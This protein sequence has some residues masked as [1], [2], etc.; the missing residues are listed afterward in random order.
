MARN[1]LHHRHVR[2]NYRV[3][4]VLVLVAVPLLAI[5][6]LVILGIGQAQSRDTYGAHLEQIAERTAAAVDTFVLRRVIDVSLLARVP[7]VREAA[8]A[9]GRIPFDAGAVREIDQ[10]WQRQQAPPPAAGNVLSNAASRFFRDVAQNDPIYS[11]LLLTDAQ[12]RLVAASEVTS[13]YFQADEEWWR[14]AFSR[15]S[16]H[17]DDV[18]WDESAR[19]YAIEISVPVLAPGSD[20]VT[21]VLKAATNSR[22]MLAAISGV[23]FGQTGEAVLVR[24]NGSLVYSRRSVEPEARFFASALL[25]ESLGLTGGPVPG[26]PAASVDRATDPSFHTHFSAQMPDGRKAIVAVAPTQLGISY[27]SLP[28]LV[29]VHEAEDELFAPVRAQ[30]WYFLALL[31]LVT[32]AVLV[33]ALW[34]SMRLAASPLDID[35]QLVK[36][37]RVHRV[38]EEDEEEEDGTLAT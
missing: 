37:A 20:E 27:P 26:P 23:R 6:A 22:E 8:L 11:E 28:W 13:D 18:T 24:K 16:P 36:H 38:D 10:Q 2:I 5:G 1:P 15:R 19:I 3:F 7:E 17:I 14:H 21:G 9:G 31:F 32:V 33:F 29:A 35:M 30:V 4:T 12:G 34:F 25:F